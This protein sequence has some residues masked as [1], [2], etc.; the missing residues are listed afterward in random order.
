[1][2]AQL[3]MRVGLG[4]EPKESFTAPSKTS[5]LRMFV[6]GGDCSSTN[7]ALIGCKQSGCAYTFPPSMF[8]RIRPPG[9]LGL[10]MRGL[11]DTRI[12]KIG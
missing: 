3:P 2:K 11:Y 8:D 6:F 5:L 1:M 12:S 10:W 9:S 4:K 7:K